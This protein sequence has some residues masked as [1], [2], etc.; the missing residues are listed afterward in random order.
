MAWKRELNFQFQIIGSS[1]V[2]LRVGS[3]IPAFQDLETSSRKAWGLAVR[4]LGPNGSPRAI[5]HRDDKSGV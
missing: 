4:I 2:I 5:R 1:G 3:L